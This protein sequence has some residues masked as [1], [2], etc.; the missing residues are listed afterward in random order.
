MAVKV[1]VPNKHYNTTAFGVQFVDGVA[2]FEDEAFAKQVAERF[3]YQIEVEEKPKA[4]KKA[5]AKK[6]APKKEEE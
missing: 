6:K 3:G 5:P 2:V 1:I 4:E